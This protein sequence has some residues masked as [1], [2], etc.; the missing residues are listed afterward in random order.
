MRFPSTFV[1]VCLLF[2]SIGSSS[3][4]D[5]GLSEVLKARDSDDPDVCCSGTSYSY[6]CT[7]SCGVC[8]QVTCDVCFEMPHLSLL[9]GHNAD[10]VHGQL[11]E[12]CDNGAYVR[13]CI[14]TKR[15]AALL[16]SPVPAVFPR[17]F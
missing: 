9:R 10:G 14:K 17:E 13:C 15:D 4:I 7:A 1:A 6:C 8:E 11:N 12:E 3:P 16:M 5:D 2:A